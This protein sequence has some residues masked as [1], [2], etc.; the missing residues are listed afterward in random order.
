MRPSLAASSDA[1]EITFWQIHTLVLSMHC[2]CMKNRHDI[3][4]CCVGFEA[5]DDHTDGVAL[6][7]DIL[8]IS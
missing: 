8:K 5:V 1:E 3:R 6:V 4:G 2:T 7:K